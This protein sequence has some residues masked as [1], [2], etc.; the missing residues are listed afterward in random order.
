MDLRTNIIGKKILQN[1]DIL[2]RDHETRRG[3][4]SR[5]FRA[6]RRRDRSLTPL[7]RT[8]ALVLSLVETAAVMH[9]DFTTHTHAVAAI[10]R[11]ARHPV[12]IVKRLG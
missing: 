7:A 5:S 1:L 11:E 3:K 4:L 12:G 9:L 8:Q 10:K 6:G 2:A